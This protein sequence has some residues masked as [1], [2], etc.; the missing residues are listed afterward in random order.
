MEFFKIPQID[1]WN[2]LYVQVR[3]TAFSGC[4]VVGIRFYCDP[5]VWIEG[6]FLGQDEQDVLDTI[7]VG[8]PDSCS[9]C[10]WAL[11]FVGRPTTSHS[12]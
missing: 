3:A 7:A 10:S 11:N 4:F 9:S 8:G 2:L 12:C 6:R 5:E 1:I